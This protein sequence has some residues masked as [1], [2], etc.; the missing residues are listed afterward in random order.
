VNQTFHDKQ[1]LIA[2]WSFDARPIL[3]RFHLWLEDVD[4]CWHRG[5]PIRELFR[6]MS[7]LDGRME[8]LM[9]MTGAVTALG[10]QVFARFGAGAAL[11]KAGLNQVKKDAD[12]ISAYAM[13]ESLWYLS[14][15]LPEN[16]AI[17]VCLGEG[18]MPKAG[19]T[20]EMGAN[21]QIGFGRVYARP[22]VA[23]RLDQRVVRLL[24]DPAYG[25]EGFY[26]ENKRAGITIWGAAIDTLENTSR[27]A[28]G[29]P[30]GPMTVLHLFD[31]P[32]KIKRPYEGYVGTL[33]LPK[34][35][36]TT[37]AEH[38]ILINYRTPRSLVAKA[39]E[40]AYPGIQRRNIHVWTLGGKS[41]VPR[42]GGLWKAWQD[43][44]VHIV[45]DGWAL[46]NGLGVFTESGTYAPTYSIGT[47]TDPSGE[48]HLFFCDGYAASAEAAQAAS[49]A[50]MLDLD[51]SLALFTSKFDLPYDKEQYVMGLDPDAADFRARLE[52]VTAV[53]LDEAS[54][55]HYREMIREG[56]DAGF[57]LARPT[58]TADD[59]FPEKR[60]EVLAVTGF[61]GP[62]PYSGAPGVE[63]VKPGTYR[64][65]VRLA[66][67]AGEKRVRFTL[68]LM[69]SFEQSRLVFNPL[70]NRFLSGEEYEHRPVKISDS[71]RIRNELQTLCAGALEFRNSE[72]IRVYFD[73]IPPE[74]IPY[75]KQR[76]LLDVLRWYKRRHPIWFSWLE[77]AEPGVRPD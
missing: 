72:A 25:W 77:I 14:R 66:T 62:D 16:H 61:M 13:S 56:L 71:G 10:T 54:V 36:V 63:E 30:T 26:S 18:L 43:E 34:Q 41:R 4:V 23:R 29:S 1:D 11:D 70:L 15:Q 32:L 46:P 59:L 47:W 7:F 45:E 76:K 44:G 60:W 37:A 24:N 12:A 2:Q 31:Q 51:A 17:L 57:D 68:R 53:P 22:E 58:L 5:E 27:F 40:L 55:R 74:V 64:A 67:A 20:P 69:E 50:P 21:P 6:P 49:L 73:R 75:D 38:A 3:G 48:L 28:K 8:R 19:E 52:A 39:I 35:V 42:I 33:I 9:A 65:T